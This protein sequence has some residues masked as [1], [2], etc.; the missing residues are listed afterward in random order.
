MKYW[1]IYIFIISCHLYPYPGCQQIGNALSAKN[2]SKYFNFVHCECSC[3]ECE[4]L[5]KSQC[6]QCKHYHPQGLNPFIISP[7]SKN[8][9]S[10][11]F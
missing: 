11:K 6:S 7:K 9:F 8:S 1:Y 3:N 2:D 10:I 4:Q 5:P